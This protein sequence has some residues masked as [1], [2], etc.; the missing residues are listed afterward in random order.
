MALQ[1]VGLFAN[2]PAYQA[3]QAQLTLCDRPAAAADAAW[4]LW[5]APAVLGATLLGK[6]ANVPGANVVVRGARA[7]MPVGD[8]QLIGVPAGGQQQ[9]N[10]TAETAGSLRTWLAANPGAALTIVVNVTTG[11]ST[12]FAGTIV[13]ILNHEL[14]AHAE[15]YADFLI[16]EAAA[17]G[18]GVLDTADQ[19]HQALA[20]GNPRYRLIGAEY[21][22]THPAADQAP[23]YRTRMAQDTVANA[24][25]PPGV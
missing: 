18:T 12:T 8:T 24:T 13:E 10:L 25:L 5:P 3:A 15:P 4:G 7:R 11:S 22:T 23:R 9:H 14:S 1:F 2:D 6:L 16:A 20:A 19:Q 17:A 21:V